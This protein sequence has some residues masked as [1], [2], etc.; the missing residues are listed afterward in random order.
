M[1]KKRV[2]VVAHYLE[3]L[4]GGSRRTVAQ[5]LGVLASFAAGEGATPESVRWERLTRRETT[6]V[7]AAIM[8]RFAPATA[9]KVLSVLRGVLRTA[10]D[11]G[12]MEEAAFQSAASLEGVKARKPV[13]SVAVKVCDEMIDVLFGACEAEK[14]ASGKRDAAMLALFLS[15]GMR[16][17]EAAHLDVADYHAK[18]GTLHIRGE[19]PEYDRVAK[20]A[21]RAKRAVD[22]WLAVRTG[23]AGPLLLPVDR[24]GIIRFRRLTEQAV[25]DIFG[26]IAARAGVPALTLRELRRAYVVSLV[27]AGKTLE[28][29]QAAAGH[30]SWLT[31]AV[32]ASLADDQS[33]GWFRLR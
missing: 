26:R 16:R 6:R 27:R 1:A 28:E 2:D 31:P 15:T 21:R 12:L 29:T 3:G 20:L 17:A 33:L 7:R 13:A 18:R 19:R 24:G 8:E 9:N 11:L 25:Y 32:Y 5:S 4:S 23:E 30:A 10:R 22:A 14:G